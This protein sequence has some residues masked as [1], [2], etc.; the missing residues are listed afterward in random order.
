MK[1]YLRASF[2]YLFFAS[3][4]FVNDVNSSGPKVRSLNKWRD[5]RFEVQRGVAEDFVCWYW[6]LKLRVILCFV[7]SVNTSYAA[8]HS[9]RFIF[10]A[11]SYLNK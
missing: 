4:D 9:R 5:A 7:T 3:V 8:S 11:E 10:G 6:T 2:T 1:R